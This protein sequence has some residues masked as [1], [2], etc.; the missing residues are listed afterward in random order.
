MPYISDAKRERARWM[1]LAELITHI[2]EHD[3]CGRH[4]A[5]KQIRDA[6]GD[7]KLIGKWEDAT[8]DQLRRRLPTD[9]PFPV[10]PGSA[11]HGPTQVPDRPPY[12]AGFWQQARIDGD[13][14][15]DPETES[16][17][18]LL[19]LKDSVFRLWSGPS[20][21]SAGTKSGI[22]KSRKEKTNPQYTSVITPSAPRG[23]DPAKIPDILECL[24]TAP[25][26]PSTTSMLPR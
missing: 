19:I 2:T 25:K 6:L 7:R 10:P 9:A 22:E 8:A 1:T 24:N 4:S 23:P 21:T 16:W 14:V 12:K 3:G 18:T 5:E 26:F 17:R 13:R 20:V 11:D 15:F